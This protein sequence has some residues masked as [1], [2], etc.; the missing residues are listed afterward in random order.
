MNHSSVAQHSTA[1]G[2]T[3]NNAQH[4]A[5]A[6]GRGDGNW[7]GFVKIYEPLQRRSAQQNTRKMR[8]ILFSRKGAELPTITFSRGT[9]KPV[10]LAPT[11]LGE[12]L[13]NG[14]EPRAKTHNISPSQTGAE[15]GQL[16]RLCRG[17][18]SS[19]KS[20]NKARGKCTPFCFREKTRS[21]LPSSLFVARAIHLAL[22]RPSSGSLCLMTA[23]HARAKT[24][25][26]SP[27]QTG[28]EGPIGTTL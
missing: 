27:S 10:G 15:R 3:R 4:F 1:R 16:A 11:E 20:H 7:H 14:C 19:V 13:P 2:A 5:L 18:H 8:C 28:A 12:P 22:L 23:S 25:S 6:N 9:R 24:H 26:I 21:C 17:S